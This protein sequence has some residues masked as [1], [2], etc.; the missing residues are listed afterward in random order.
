MIWYAGWLMTRSTC[1]CSQ[2]GSGEGLMSPR[3]PCTRRSRGR[4]RKPWSSWKIE[5][6]S[7]SSWIFATRES[8]ST[9]SRAT[10][11]SCRR[12]CEKKIFIENKCTVHKTRDS[13]IIENLG[14]FFISFHNNLISGLHWI[15]PL[16][17]YLDYP[18]MSNYKHSIFL[19][20][21]QWNLEV[22]CYSFPVGRRSRFP[23]KLRS[24][25]RL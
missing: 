4:P 13:F 1:P 25:R 17:K 16:E 19:Y 24:L 14:V 9:F 7:G 6:S 8:R 18:I 11:S 5:K 21:L 20:R 22:F 12:I 3:T 10:D 2:R 15:P 23:P